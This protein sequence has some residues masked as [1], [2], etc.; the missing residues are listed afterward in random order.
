[1]KKLIFKIKSKLFNLFVKRYLVTIHPN[2]L[3]HFTKI[4]E[5]NNIY[6]FGSE[7]AI[8]EYKRIMKT[9][10][11]KK[12]KRFFYKTV[13]YNIGKEE[14]LMVKP[15]TNT[16]KDKL[17]YFFA[18][19]YLRFFDKKMYQSIL[20]YKKWNGK[21]KNIDDKIDEY[22]A[23]TTVEERIDRA[24]EYRILTDEDYKFLCDYSKHKII[25]PNLILNQDSDDYNDLTLI[26][27]SINN[28]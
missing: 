7:R 9:L 10:S 21:I 12:Y 2:L 18:E 11:S 16:F 25:L 17:Y 19:T 22:M 1:M 26:P 15:Y 5:S 4:L 14:I 23:N 24:H 3:S 13:K 27:K 28:N 6:G 20:L 8:N